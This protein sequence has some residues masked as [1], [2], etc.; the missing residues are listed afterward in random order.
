MAGLPAAKP[1]RSPTPK[2]FGRWTSLARATTKQ[3]S[4]GWHSSFRRGTYQLTPT[5]HASPRSHVMTRITGASTQ[6][7]SSSPV[8][9]ACTTAP[10]KASPSRILSTNSLLSCPASPRL[11]SGRSI[12]RLPTTWSSIST[13]LAAPTSP[14]SCLSPSPPN[15]KCLS[16]TPSGTCALTTKS[17]GLITPM[18]RVL[19]PSTPRTDGDPSPGA[20]VT[21]TPTSTNA[22]SPHSKP[23]S[24]LSLRLSKRLPSWEV[25]SGG[26]STMPRHLST[27]LSSPLSPAFPVHGVCRRETRPST[28][29]SPASPSTTLSGSS[30]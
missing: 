2:R 21:A 13:M 3:A 5:M 30:T 20:T 12:A 6:K 29:T 23:P 28:G 1:F 16:T 26:P 11:A 19:V 22:P 25:L 9:R 15:P 10:T 8:E 27:S 18:T 14:T 7:L 24:T 4:L 17:P